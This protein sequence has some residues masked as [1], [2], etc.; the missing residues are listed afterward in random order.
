ML[1][2]I[3]GSGGWIC[4]TEIWMIREWRFFLTLLHVTRGIRT[5]SVS[6][7][8]R[9]TLQ[10]GHATE[11][12]AIMQIVSYFPFVCMLLL[13]KGIL[14]CQF[15][16]QQPC[17]SAPFHFHVAPRS[18]SRSSRPLC[19]DLFCYPSL[20]EFDMC[21]IFHLYL[22]LSTVCIWQMFSLMYYTLSLRH[23]GVSE[24]Q[25][26]HLWSSIPHSI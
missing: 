7:V 2:D 22:P 24:V 14:C 26:G 1:F 25:I 9:S 10:K 12:S 15:V 6:S 5:I 8:L 13:Q 17:I 19:R 20:P 16:S 21:H 4:F 23:T 11:Y 3:R 18:M